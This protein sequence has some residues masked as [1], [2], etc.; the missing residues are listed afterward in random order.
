[1]TPQAYTKE[2]REPLR[3]PEKSSSKIF[4]KGKRCDKQGQMKLSF[5]MIFSIILIIIFIS[6]S[7]FAIKKF[8]NLGDTA[9]IA[10]FANNLQTDID[11][12][13]KGTQSSQEKEY[14]LP[15]KISHVCFAD[16]SLYPA[17]DRGKY[18]IYFSELKQLHQEHENLFFYPGG[19]SEGL[20]S[21]EIKH[22]DL[23]K[24]ILRDNPFCVENIKGKIKLVIEKQYG[25]ALVTI[26]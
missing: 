23:A 22:L 19:S 1:M 6:F 8:L 7:F 16:Y 3:G 13:W 4:T 17:G 2:V 9:Q 5:G 12:A 11:K 24:T 25:E 10:K 26:K 15:S 20:N 21:K 18:R 14:F